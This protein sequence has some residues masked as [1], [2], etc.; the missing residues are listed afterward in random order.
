MSRPARVWFS[1]TAA[2]VV[3]AL[4]LQIPITA[5]AVGGAFSTPAARV[6]NLFSFFTILTNLTELGYARVAVN[7]AGIAVLFLV[8]S[9]GAMVLDRRLDRSRRTAPAPR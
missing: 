8:L 5:G 7:C 3:V 9:A 6:A 2:V 1:V 4:A